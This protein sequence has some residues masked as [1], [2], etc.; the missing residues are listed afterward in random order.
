M[1]NNYTCKHVFE[2]LFYVDHCVLNILYITIFD[3]FD[4]QDTWW[5]NDFDVKLP[6]AS[7]FEIL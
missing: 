2:H 7:C 1:F 4:Y 5:N 3:H 6:F